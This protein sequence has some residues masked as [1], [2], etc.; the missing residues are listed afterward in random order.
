[1]PRSDLLGLIL[2]LAIGFLVL[3][4]IVFFIFWRVRHP[5][6]TK[7]ASAPSPSVSPSP[8]AVAVVSPSPQPSLP[9]IQE[10]IPATPSTNTS[11]NQANRYKSESSD[12]SFPSNPTG[13]QPTKQIIIEEVTQTVPVVITKTTT[14]YFSGQPCSSECVIIP[15]SDDGYQTV[16]LTPLHRSCS[17]WTW[18]GRR[19]NWA[20]AA[21]SSSAP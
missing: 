8:S 3:G 16:Q 2:R 21:A 9:S 5:I 4:A 20:A 12:V 6:S 17:N 15:S 7:Q 1:M 18:S 10:K 19:E 14:T 11:S 13:K